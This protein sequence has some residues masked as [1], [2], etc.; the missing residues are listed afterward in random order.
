MPFCLRC[1][2]RRRQHT[3][4]RGLVEIESLSGRSRKWTCEVPM[5]IVTPSYMYTEKD[6]AKH[7]ATD[8]LK[9][10]QFPH[11]WVPL[12]PCRSLSNASRHHNLSCEHGALG[13]AATK[14]SCEASADSTSGTRSRSHTSYAHEKT[15]LP[16]LEWKHK[17]DWK[18]TTTKLCALAPRRRKG[19]EPDEI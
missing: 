3:A 8:N 1:K 18:I 17:D 2:K 13:I 16:G 14:S 4:L 12:E 5:T 7:H 9:S 6:I 11:A 10:Q 15:S 19:K